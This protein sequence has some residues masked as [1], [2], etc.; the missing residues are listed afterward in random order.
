M[1]QYKR[2]RRGRDPLTCK[3]EGIDSCKDW[4]AIDLGEFVVKEFDEV[5]F[6]L[7]IL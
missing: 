1:L 6:L 4:Y 7:N 2:K 3:I 5:V